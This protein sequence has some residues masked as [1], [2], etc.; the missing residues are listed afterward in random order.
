MGR[1][2]NVVEP[3]LTGPVI[4]ELS[5]TL[6]PQRCDVRAASLDLEDPSSSPSPNPRASLEREVSPFA[7]NATVGVYPR[8]IVQEIKI[9]EE[10]VVPVKRLCIIA[11]T[12]SP[13]PPII[14]PLTEK[15]QSRKQRIKLIK[16]A[17]CDRVQCDLEEHDIREVGE[18]RYLISAYQIERQKQDKS[19]RDSRKAIKA[20]KT[21]L[22]NLKIRMKQA[23]A[24]EYRVRGQR[25]KPKKH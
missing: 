19:E 21:R 23:K 1:A 18:A 22:R 5:E 8:K 10:P 3:T 24:K 16:Q 25:F 13:S 6:S 4:V 9:E 20:G 11:R 7:V 2:E 17:S 12:H 15:Y 14:L